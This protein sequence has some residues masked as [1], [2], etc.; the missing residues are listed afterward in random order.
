MRE[1]KFRAWDKCLNKMV[2]SLDVPSIYAERNGKLDLVNM[3]KSLGGR[4]I[5]MQHT[6]LEDVVGKEIFEGDIILG[7]TYGKDADKLIGAVVF[8]P[9]TGAY[10]W[11]NDETDLIAES[12]C[13]VMVI[14]NIYEDAELLES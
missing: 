10:V 13:T 12:C 14:G 1:I 8:S 7:T 4:Y 3:F 5:F 2:Y 9:R 11:S 6:G